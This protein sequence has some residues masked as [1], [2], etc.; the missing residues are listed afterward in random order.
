M[1]GSDGTARALREA[2]AMGKPAVVAN[3]GILPELVEEGVSGRVVE[4]TPEALAGATLQLLKDKELRVSMGRAAY[5]RAHRDFRLDHQAEE[6]ERF[7]QEMVHL[8]R[9]K[10]R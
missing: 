6:V 3:R 7:Y 4:D 10:R 9:W 5:E 8:G 1:A 2:M